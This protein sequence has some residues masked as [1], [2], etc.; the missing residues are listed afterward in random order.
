MINIQ[1]ITIFNKEFL[2]K[3]FDN[4]VESYF[5]DMSY[6]INN[7]IYTLDIKYI[8]LTKSKF[9]PYN[10]EFIKKLSKEANHTLSINKALIKHFLHKSIL[11]FM[12]NIGCTVDDEI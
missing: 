10:P 12:N 5:Q 8:Y 2:L 9:E 11:D 6:D 4:S 7:L 1:N 3:E